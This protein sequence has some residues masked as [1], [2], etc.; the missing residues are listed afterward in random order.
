M[1]NHIK[2]GILAAVL[3]ALQGCGFSD[4]PKIEALKAKVS[5]QLLDPASAQFRKTKLLKDDEGFCGE[6]N[7]KNKFGGYV[8]FRAFAVTPDGKVLLS[9]YGLDD[10][11]ARL[12][13]FYDLIGEISLYHQHDRKKYYEPMKR[14]RREYADVS[15]WG[16]DFS[17]WRQCTGT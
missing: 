14:L 2:C 6:V 16:S 5:E 12:E 3:I 8:G 4:N 1:T 17:G 13:K 9:P 10:T 11:I 7:G 15:D